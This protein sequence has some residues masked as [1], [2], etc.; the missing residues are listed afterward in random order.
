DSLEIRRGIRDNPWD[1]RPPNPP[2][3]V[4][5]H[6]RRPVRGRIDAAGNEVEPLE[7]DD[8]AA[9]AELFAR[10]GVKS[11]G[12]CFINSFAAAEHEQAAAAELQRR[13][14]DAWISL[15]SAIAPIMGE[16]ERGST[17]ALNAA[18]A[19]RTMGYLRRLEE[20]LQALGLRKRLL[21]IQ[22]N[23]G[24]ASVEQVAAKPV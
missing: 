12:I 1:H 2:V 9:A 19:P 18:V 21:L 5:R 16:Y 17:T 10:E 24:A 20:R 22:N 3:L 8:V 4:P 14:P 7:L 15:S 11:V 13:L 6:L 23:G